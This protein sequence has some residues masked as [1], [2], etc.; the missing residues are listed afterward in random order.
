MVIVKLCGVRTEASAEAARAAELVGLNFVAGRRRA[1]EPRLARRLAEIARPAGIVGVF[2]DPSLEL[3][4]SVHAEVGLDAVQLHGDEPPELCRAIARRL[5]VMKALAVDERFTAEHLKPYEGIVAR[6][7]FD[8][9]TEGGGQP[10][11]WSRLAEIPRSTPFLLA[12][13]LT[14]DNVGRAIA[15]VHPDGVDTASG[16]ETDG[17]P[18]PAR[19]AA[20]LTAARG[21]ATR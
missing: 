21:E 4:E 13:G 14:A 8:A 6:L 17:Q 19:I 7:L 16:I 3:V 18:D 9:R 20:F 5:P 11:D 15:E 12:G 2:I 10:F 1:V